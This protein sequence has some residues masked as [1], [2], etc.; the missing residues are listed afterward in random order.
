[1]L[2]KYKNINEF[3]IYLSKYIMVC[4]L[5]NIFEPFFTYRFYMYSDSVVGWSNA[6]T[7]I[8]N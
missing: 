6:V 1:M 2:Y 8:E 7:N 4:Q 5:K 3:N